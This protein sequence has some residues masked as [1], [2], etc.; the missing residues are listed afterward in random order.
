MHRKA[1]GK[2]RQILWR[3]EMRP[4]A[5]LFLAVSASASADQLSLPNVLSNNAVADATEVNENFDALVG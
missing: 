2:L 4:F 3:V 5:L 1:F